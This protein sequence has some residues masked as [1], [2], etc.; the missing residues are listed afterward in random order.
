MNKEKDV[1][2]SAPKIKVGISLGDINGTG[3]ELIIKALGDARMTELVTPVI[4]G[5]S[6]VISFYRKS[7]Q[8]YAEFQY[9]KTTEDR[10]LHG[11]VNLVNVWEEEVQIEPGERNVNGGKYAFLALEAASRAL[12]AGHIDVLVTG[13]VDKALIEESGTQFS[14]HTEYFGEQFKGE[15]LM[16]LAGEKLRVA[17][18]TGHKAIKDVASL[19][20]VD[21]L[22]KR[23]QTLEKSMKADFGIRKPKIAVLGL[24]PHA[25]DNGLF[26]DE[27]QQII[28]PAIRKAAEKGSIVNG[29]YA[30]DGFFGS[31]AFQGFDA[32]LAMYHDQGL[33]PFKTLAGWEGV[34]FTANLNVIRTSPDHGPAFQL[35]GKGTADETSIRNAIYMAVDIFRRRE[36]YTEIT[37]NP[38]RIMNSDELGDLK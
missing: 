27:E 33:I 16:I 5:N 20:T 18:V 34:N 11:K 37:A 9:T 6:K 4:F 25:G 38:L 14:G 17:L 7:L 35:A 28:I 21:G 12:A 3:P 8:G 22:V 2:K 19:I 31:G 13:P 29:P 15:P 32:V 1:V 36:E 24:N 30:A 10:I 26:G 23:I